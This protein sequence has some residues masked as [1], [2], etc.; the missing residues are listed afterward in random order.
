MTDMNCQTCGAVCASCAQLRRERDFFK[1]EAE[2][3]IEAIKA[4]AEGTLQPD[5][6]IKESGE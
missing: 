4:A 1:R 2:K 3:L 6:T 5:G